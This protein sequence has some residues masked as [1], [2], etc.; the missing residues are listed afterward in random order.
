LR[1]EP[2]IEVNGHIAHLQTSL[3]PLGFAAMKLKVDIVKTLM[4]DGSAD[5][6]KVDIAFTLVS[7][8]N[9]MI[10]KMFNNYNGGLCIRS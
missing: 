6:N 10:E 5:P 2:S 7:W 9:P 8:L 4:N 3:T 1:N